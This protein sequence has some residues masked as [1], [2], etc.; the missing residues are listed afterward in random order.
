MHALVLL[1][2]AASI[3]SQRLLNFNRLGAHLDEAQGASK[4]SSSFA[5]CAPKD[6]VTPSDLATAVIAN[7]F[8]GEFGSRGEVYLFTLS[9]HKQRR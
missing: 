9:Q 2:S 8:E 3:T 4:K 6:E 5:M 1:V 7:V